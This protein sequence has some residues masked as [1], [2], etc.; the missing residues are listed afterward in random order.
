MPFWRTPHDAIIYRSKLSFTLKLSLYISN[1]NT[2]PEPRFFGH[3][4]HEISKKSV[5]FLQLQIFLNH[6]QFYPKFQ[7]FIPAFTK[8][9]LCYRKQYIERFIHNIYCLP[10]IMLMQVEMLLNRTCSVLLVF[11]FHWCI[12]NAQDIIF[13]NPPRFLVKWWHLSKL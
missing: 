3:Q 9:S 13:K 5:L 12:S 2:A 11:F 1:E 7:H 4:G 8:V 10:V 6:M